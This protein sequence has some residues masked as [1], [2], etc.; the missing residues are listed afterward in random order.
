MPAAAQIEKGLTWMQLYRLRVIGGGRVTHVERVLGFGT[1]KICIPIL[2]IAGDRCVEVLDRA[3]QRPHAVD[4]HPAGIAAARRDDPGLPAVHTLD[5]H[6]QVDPDARLGCAARPG[7]VN[8]AKS[9]QHDDALS[10]QR[11]GN[12]GRGTTGLRLETEGIA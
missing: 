10:Y 11:R 1:S 12:G 8:R 4:V 7:D 2:W 6:N 9:L 5:R 3:L